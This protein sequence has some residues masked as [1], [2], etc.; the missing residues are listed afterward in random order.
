MEQGKVEHHL[1]NKKAASR[2]KERVSKENVGCA[3]KSGTQQPN[4]RAKEKG[5][6][7]RVCT[8]STMAKQSIGHL[9]K[10]TPQHGEAVL[11]VKAVTPT[12]SQAQ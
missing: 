11:K 6:Q 10:T 12:A 4:A 1:G 8:A 7:E 3:T 5:S 9:G 2:A